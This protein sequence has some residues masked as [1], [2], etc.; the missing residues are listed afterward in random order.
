MVEGVDI[1]DGEKSDQSDGQAQKTSSVSS[2]K[3]SSFDLN[4]EAISEDD[5]STTEVNDAN[6]EKDATAKG[7]V[8]SNNITSTVRQY[9]RSKMPRL[10]WTPDLHLSFVHAVERLGGQERATPKLVLQLMNVRGLS[11][12]HV[13]SHLQM[14]RS[15]KLDDTGQVLSQTNRAIQGRDQISEM[16]YR[17]IS[18]YR[19][20]RIDDSGFVPARNSHEPSRV[21]SLLQHPFSQQPFD[22]KATSSRHQQWAF[23]QHAMTMPSSLPRKFS[24][25]TKG[26]I[27]MMIFQNEHKASTSHLGNGPIRPSQFLE[28]KKWP[29][30]QMISNQG[31]NREIPLTI[32]WASSSSQH[33]ARQI[34]PTPMSLGST[35]TFQSSGWNPRTSSS[36]RQFE[37]NLHDPIIISDGFE[38]EFEP[39]FRLELQRLRENQPHPITKGVLQIEENTSIEKKLKEREWLPNLQLSLSHNSGIDD[40]KK[41][42]ESTEEID[43]M[44]SLSLSPSSSRQQS[45]PSEKHREISQTKTWSLQTNCNKATLRLST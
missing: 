1:F 12:A 26:P 38:P 18:P 25:L 7:D 24:E 16:F 4:E 5:E 36:D 33:L 35:Y 21:Q 34:R 9:V 45:Q 2:Q 27:D 39:P 20:F 32:S 6:V 29:P 19:H 17:R 40:G 13:K 44:L 43:T 14:Y 41:A 31:K 15:K 42:R 28:E 30:R 11:I 8:S 22:F 3:W 37:S 10:R 23:N